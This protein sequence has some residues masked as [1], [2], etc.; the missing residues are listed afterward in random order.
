MNNEELLCEG[1]GYPIHPCLPC[2]EVAL[3]R[4][5][6][7]YPNFKFPKVYLLGYTGVDLAS[8]T[9]YLQDT[10]QIEFLEE[11]RAAKEEGLDDGEIL[12]SFYAKA[13]YASLTNKKNKNITRTRA[14]A[15]NIR[16]ILDSG[17]GSVIEHIQLNFMIT[18]C[19]RVFTHELV[20]HRV[21]TAF[22][23]TSGRYVRSDVLNVVIDP[24]LEP[25]YDLFEEARL[26]LQE[27]YKEVEKRL[28]MD[29]VKDFDTKKKLTSAMRRMLPNGQSNEMGVSLNLRSLRHTIEMRTSRHA[30]WEIR[31]IFNQIYNLV[32]N[33]YPIMFNDAKEEIV[34]GLVEITFRNRKV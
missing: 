25:A 19:S 14:I 27:W 31:Y 26:Y 2:E 22:S 5:D 24:I 29:N 10:D 20:R 28:D 13:C 8:L 1:C 3:L 15:D 18:D 30:E 21:G 16:G 7:E 17:H 12:C 4:G 34:N 32:K 11:I 9:E 23:Q 6:L 33:K